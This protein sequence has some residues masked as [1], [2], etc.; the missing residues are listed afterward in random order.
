LCNT[1]YDHFEFTQDNA[2]LKRLYE[3][4]KGSAI[5]FLDTLVEDPKGRG[6]V[7]SPS[8][9]PEVPHTGGGSVAAGPTIDRQIVRDLFKHVIEAS[10][11]LGVDPDLRKQLTDTRAKIAPNMIGERG[12]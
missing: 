7:T 11:I 2:F 4:M 1:L 3:P 10:Q 9:S 6:L 8:L 5:F 12:Q